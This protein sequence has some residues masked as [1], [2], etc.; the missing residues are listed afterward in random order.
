MRG[1]G[2]EAETPTIVVE[3]RHPA[4]DIADIALRSHAAPRPPPQ[5]MN[6]FTN[7]A[8]IALALFGVHA[9]RREGLPSRFTITHAGIALVGIGSFAF[10]ATLLYE[11]QLLDELPMIYTSLVLSYC[12]LETNKRGTAPWGGQ[13]LPIGLVAIGV[14]HRSDGIWIRCESSAYADTFLLFARL[15][16]TASRPHHGRI[17]ECLWRARGSVTAC[18]RGP[19]H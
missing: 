2:K 15:P 11:C 5:P 19:I 4:D 9:C 8:F 18:K 6:T 13:W 12:I 17:R 7:V 10:H 3:T 14:C 16:C 1:R